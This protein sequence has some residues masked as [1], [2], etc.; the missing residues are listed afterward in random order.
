M[1]WAS[2]L[3]FRAPRPLYRRD[4]RIGVILGISAA[5]LESPE[6]NTKASEEVKRGSHVP[7]SV[8]QGVHDNVALR[9]NKLDALNYGF[10][11]R[12]KELPDEIKRDDAV[13]VVALTGP[14]P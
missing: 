10:I 4:L 3:R 1:Q 6:R 12:L 13:R 2:A 7:Y 8:L 11:D 9:P 5:E 14:R